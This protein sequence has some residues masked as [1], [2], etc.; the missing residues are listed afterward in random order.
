MLKLASP[1]NR[2]GFLPS[3]MNLVSALRERRICDNIAVIQ[4]KHQDKCNETNAEKIGNC[5]RHTV[6]RTRVLKAWALSQ[7]CKQVIQGAGPQRGGPGALA[8]RPEGP[9]KVP[10]GMLGFTPQIL[11]M[12]KLKH[13][14]KPDNATSIDTTP[15]RMLQ[16]AGFKR[17]DSAT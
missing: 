8:G 6:W 11:W 3:C 4:H 16:H 12:S 14:V 10:P 1:G 2:N 7:A 9:G 13:C 15:A 5:F 17:Q